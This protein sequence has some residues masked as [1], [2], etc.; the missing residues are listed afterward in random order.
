MPDVPGTGAPTALAPGESEEPATAASATQLPNPFT[1]SMLQRI[2]I[3]EAEA[4]AFRATLLERAEVARFLVIDNEEA[5][6]EILRLQEQVREL[7]KEIIRLTDELR[8]KPSAPRAPE[9]I[10]PN[11]KYL[12][13]IERLEAVIA[14][15]EAKI[16]GLRPTGE[17]PVGPTFDE[18]EALRD[19]IRKAR[20]DMIVASQNLRDSAVGTVPNVDLVDTMI[21]IAVFLTENQ[22]EG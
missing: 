2:A 3:L 4:Q 16:L 15:M 12:E 9:P 10:D 7:E 17:P 20:T 8:V 1:L 11:P 22:P 14:E 19:I 5:Q 13:E 21:R 6:D 18:L